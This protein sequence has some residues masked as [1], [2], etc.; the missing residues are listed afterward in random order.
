MAIWIASEEMDED[1]RQQLFVVRPDGRDP[2]LLTSIQ[3]P[4][5]CCPVWSL[6]GQQVLG[7]GFVVV[8]AQT[9]NVVSQV[10]ADEVDSF[11]DAWVKPSAGQ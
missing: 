3:G 1:G 9:G 7:L 2:H 5:T 8:D 4:G 10:P 11:A 6:D